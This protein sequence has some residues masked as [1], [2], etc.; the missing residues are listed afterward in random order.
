VTEADNDTEDNSD[1]DDNE[2]FQIMSVDEFK[3]AVAH[4]KSCRTTNP[5]IDVM[6]ALENLYP[7][8]DDVI[9]TEHM[10]SLTLM[11]TTTSK[12]NT[13]EKL[14]VLQTTLHQLRR[15]RR[16]TIEAFA[17]EQH[18]DESEHL[19]THNT[20]TPVKKAAADRK[21]KQSRTN[22]IDTSNDE[23]IRK[24]SRISA[25]KQQHATGGDKAMIDATTSSNEQQRSARKPRATTQQ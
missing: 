23:P 5:V 9:D 25:S 1:E 16:K 3:Q 4:N 2:K 11:V 18:E 21:R 6:V 12:L 20:L 19:Q 14:N 22:S 24:S 8:E 13:A 10:F 7:D 15:R 17:A